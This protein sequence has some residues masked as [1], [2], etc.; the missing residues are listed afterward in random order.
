MKWGSELWNIWKK[1]IQDRRKSI[2]KWPEVRLRLV[3]V[4]KCEQVGVPGG[5]WGQ[6][7]SEEWTTARVSGAFSFQL[8]SRPGSSIKLR[9]CLIRPTPWLLL[10]LILFPKVF[11]VSFS[12]LL[13]LVYSGHR[14]PTN[15]SS[16]EVT[17]SDISS[18]EID[19][20]HWSVTS[21][22]PAPELQMDLL[23]SYP[24]LSLCLSMFPSLPSFDS[25]SI[26]SNHP[27]LPASYILSIS[28]SVAPILPTVYDF[29][30]A[31]FFLLLHGLLRPT[32]EICRITL[33]ITLTDEWSSIS[34]K[35]L[36]FPD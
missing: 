5:Q 29:N 19:P 15:W 20:V 14:R 2:C 1:S 28:P 18:S 27:S 10:S 36:T 12:H 24:A 33:S 26:T 16:S 11:P 9:M 4:R 35:P 13:P 30:C 3:R 22:G 23:F 17:T 25:Q 34:F 31:S 7:W 6:K 21:D 8:F 32:G